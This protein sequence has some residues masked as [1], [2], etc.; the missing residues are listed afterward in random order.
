MWLQD[1]V[2]RTV[3]PLWM[4]EIEKP[5]FSQQDMVL[6]ILDKP[7]GTNESIGYTMKLFLSMFLY[8]I[9]WI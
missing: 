8:K 6:K 9:T 2:P 4:S 1:S 5:K 7:H 3:I